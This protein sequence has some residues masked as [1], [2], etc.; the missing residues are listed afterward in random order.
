LNGNQK[1]DKGDN[2]WQNINFGQT[3]SASVKYTF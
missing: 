2:N 3:I 1:Y